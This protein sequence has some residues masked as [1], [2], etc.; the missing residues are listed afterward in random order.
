MFKGKKM[1]GTTPGGGKL[2]REKTDDHVPVPFTAKEKTI[3]RLLS[4]LSMWPFRNKSFV[5]SLETAQEVI[6]KQTKLEE[7]I[8]RHGRTRG[9]LNDLDLILERDRDQ[10]RRELLDERNRLNDA[11]FEHEASAEK[12]QIYKNK[13]AAELKGS[14]YELEKKELEYQKDLLRL[15]KEVAL[16]AE[17][18]QPVKKRRTPISSAKLKEIDRV[19]KWRDKELQ[20][21]EGGKDT[22][23]SKEERRRIVLAETERKMELI[24][25]KYKDES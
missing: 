8:I 12:Y 6:E 3:Q 2:M 23:T 17:A 20:K 15:K 1:L 5:K 24:E 19:L 18:E 10:R 25:E 22:V 7:V 14:Q 11:L 21:I 4:M 13:K 9:Q 16:L